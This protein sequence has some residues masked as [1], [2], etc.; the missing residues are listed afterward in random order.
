[1]TDGVHDLGWVWLSQELMLGHLSRVNPWAR[2]LKETV[3]IAMH[4]GLCWPGQRG[5]ALSGW[6][7][8]WGLHP[9]LSVGLAGEQRQR[10]PCSLTLLLPSILF[11]LF[12]SHGATAASRIVQETSS[13]CPKWVRLSPSTGLTSL[14]LPLADPSPGVYN[15]VVVPATYSSFL[16]CGPISNK[17]GPPPPRRGRDGEGQLRDGRGWGQQVDVSVAQMGWGGKMES[18]PGGKK[19]LCPGDN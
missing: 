7:A 6:P 17:A 18:C 1:M 2:V 8:L 16:Y 9:E 10:P 19:E 3:G 5:W 13:I 4:A 15:E 11:P 12:H 14:L